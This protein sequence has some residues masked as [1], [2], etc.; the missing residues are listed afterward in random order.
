[1]KVEVLY[2]FGG[3]RR[4]DVV[5]VPADKV[6]ALRRLRWV[7]AVEGG[8]PARRPRRMREKEPNVDAVLST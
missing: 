3:A 4:G 6:D 5:E 7:K 8:P 2:P 1:M